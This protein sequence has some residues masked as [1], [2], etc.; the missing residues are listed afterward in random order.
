MARLAR[1]PAGFRAVVIPAGGVS[2]SLD[3]PVPA[4]VAP[5][6]H[7]VERVFG[8]QTG[9]VGGDV[10]DS[11]FRRNRA[12]CPALIYCYKPTELGIV[13]PNNGP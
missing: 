4:N 13:N 1:I 10:A 6:V 2:L 7:Q 9:L 3:W 11:N 8:L 12:D 5:A